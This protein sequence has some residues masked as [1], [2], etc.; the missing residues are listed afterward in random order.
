MLVCNKE[1]QKEIDKRSLVV[2][3]PHKE[4]RSNCLA[5]MYVSLNRDTSK[6]VVKKF[7]EN[8]NHV[9]HLPEHSHLLKSHRMV[10]EA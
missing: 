5:S 2:D 10:S 3:Q 7:E 4:T 1:G 8:H 9:L 6:W